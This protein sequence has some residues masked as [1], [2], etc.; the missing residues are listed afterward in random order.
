MQLVDLLLLLRQGIEGAAE[1]ASVISAVDAAII[2]T[3]GALK[4]RDGERL[5]Q[6]NEQINHLG[7]DVI[8]LVAGPKKDY[9][10]RPVPTRSPV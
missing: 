7:T 8:G 2:V 1:A 9:N 4:R 3:S 5:S 10:L 6:L